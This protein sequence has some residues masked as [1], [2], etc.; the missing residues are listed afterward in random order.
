MQDLY[1]QFDDTV[2]RAIYDHIISTGFAPKPAQLAALLNC[3]QP[4]I[5]AA[6]ERLVDQRAIGLDAEGHVFMAIPFATQPTG[7]RVI[8]DVQTWWANCAWDGL[9]VPALLKC[10]ATIET[11]CPATGDP[12]H[13]IVQDNQPLP[14][15]CVLHMAIPLIDWWNDI[16]S[17]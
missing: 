4:A 17:T 5:S 6:F 15:D 2:R 8:S 3:P 10:N 9:G 1:V 11:T 14:A 7:V 12:L 16:G 13:V